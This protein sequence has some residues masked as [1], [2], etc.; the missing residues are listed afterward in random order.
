MKKRRHHLLTKS[1]GERLNIRMLF[2]F[3]PT[4]SNKDPGLL[5]LVKEL[6]QSVAADQ[7]C[8]YSDSHVGLLRKEIAEF[9]EVTASEKEVTGGDIQLY[10]YGAAP[11]P[12]K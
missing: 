5:D 8:D 6:V 12:Q 10:L 1:L 2:V 11:S 4:N 9:K 3:R 7:R